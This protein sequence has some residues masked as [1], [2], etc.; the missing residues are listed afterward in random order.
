MKPE[1]KKRR[2]K[3]PAGGPSAKSPFRRVTMVFSMIIILWLT[4]VAYEKFGIGDARAWVGD[5][6]V[7][8]LI[9]FLVFLAAAV[10]VGLL[11][12][13]KKLRQ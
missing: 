2:E 9:L 3:D 7:L 1:P 10:V 11:M 12:M 6:L 4:L 13:I 8:I 5:V